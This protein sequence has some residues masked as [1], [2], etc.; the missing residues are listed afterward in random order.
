M[1]PGLATKAGVELPP[2]IHWLLATIEL[3]WPEDPHAKKPATFQ[4]LLDVS[5][6]FPTDHELWTLLT[7]AEQWGYIASFENGDR[8][9]SCWRMTPLGREAVRHSYELFS[10]RPRGCD[11]VLF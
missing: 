6:E 4:F 11:E 5:D 2:R 3:S 9:P 1:I 10:A 8:G 7:T